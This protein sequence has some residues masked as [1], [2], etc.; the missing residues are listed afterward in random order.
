MM[1]AKEI[2]SAL[3]ANKSRRFIIFHIYSS[4]VINRPEIWCASWF[5][6]VNC[7]KSR[8]VAAENGNLTA[9]EWT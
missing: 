7:T 6:Q 4:T 2:S 3:T 8:N 1:N 5:L 9:D